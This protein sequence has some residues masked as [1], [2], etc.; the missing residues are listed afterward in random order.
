MM[1]D[2]FVYCYG[3][4]L[5]ALHCVDM[6]LLLHCRADYIADAASHALSLFNFHALSSL[7]LFGSFP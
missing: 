1:I 7:H 2:V 3:F 5:C 4:P 6:Y